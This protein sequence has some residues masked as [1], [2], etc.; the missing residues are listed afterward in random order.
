MER[1]VPSPEEGAV[2]HTH[3]IGAA[4]VGPGPGGRSGAPNKQVHG[5]GGN[6][7]E[8]GSDPRTTLRGF[9]R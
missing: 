6:R 4:E 1:G 3:D 8:S 2:M 9:L 5:V 7:K